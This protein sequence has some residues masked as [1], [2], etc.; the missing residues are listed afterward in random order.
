L[1]GTPGAADVGAFANIKITVS[2]GTS[3]ASLPAFTVTVS[4]PVDGPPTIGGTP[5]TSVNVGSAYS[6]TPTASDPQG[7]ALTF[8]IQNQ[9]SWANFN[10]NTGQLSGTPAAA[11]VGTSANI[12]IGVTNGTSS[13]ALPAF[14]INVTAITTGSATITWTVPTLN[15]DGSA[16]VNLAGYHLYYGTSAANLSQTVQITNP[17]ITTYMVGNLAP[18]TWYFAMVDYTSTGEV[19]GYSNMGSKTIQ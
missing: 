5:A 16:L 13:A 19:S 2:N 17:S 6:F 11:D 14:A 1:S 12:V 3:A 9:P 4:Q 8:S 15:T 18:G 10:T 7:H